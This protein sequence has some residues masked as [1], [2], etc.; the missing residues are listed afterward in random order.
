MTL[1]VQADVHEKRH[2]DDQFKRIET[3]QAEISSLQRS[4]CLLSGDLLS[5]MDNFA[6]LVQ[7]V[8]AIQ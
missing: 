8:P 1:K 5:L 6:K 7:S 3:N 4:S 2:R